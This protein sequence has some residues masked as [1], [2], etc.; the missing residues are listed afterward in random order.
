MPDYEELREEIFKFFCR[1]QHHMNKSEVL[2]LFR[3]A[4]DE[5]DDGVVFVPPVWPRATSKVVIDRWPEYVKHTGS[6]GE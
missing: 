2:S 5:E 3:T 4:E 6:Q 1:A